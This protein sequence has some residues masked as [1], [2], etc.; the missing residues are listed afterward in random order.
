LA[1]RIYGYDKVSTLYPTPTF[2]FTVE[3]LLDFHCCDQTPEKTNLKEEKF[4]LAYGSVHDLLVLLFLGC[5]KA[6]HHGGEHM[7]EQSSSPH[8][9]QAATRES[10]HFYSEHLPRKSLSYESTDG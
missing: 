4:I 9:G 2:L 5:V 1:L 7:V 10:T 3:K 6:E 8:G